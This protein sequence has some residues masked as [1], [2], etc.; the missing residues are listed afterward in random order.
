MDLGKARIGFSWN[1]IQTFVYQRKEKNNEN[2][3]NYSWRNSSSVSALSHLHYLVT[4][5]LLRLFAPTTIQNPTQGINSLQILSLHNKWLLHYLCL[6]L[7]SL[8]FLSPSMATSVLLSGPFHAFSQHSKCKIAT[9]KSTAI[10]LDNVKPIKNP[11]VTL[12]N[13]TSFSRNHLGSYNVLARASIG[14][15]DGKNTVEDE[16]LMGEDSAVFDLEKQKISS[17]LYFGAILGVV[18]FVLDVVWIDNSTGFGKLFIESLSSL[19]DSHEVGFSVCPYGIILDWLDLLHIGSSLSIMLNILVL[20]SAADM[21]DSFS[22][23]CNCFLKLNLNPTKA[24][25]Y[26]SEP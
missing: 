20:C 14:D 15:T 7:F 8:L 12:T 3:I 2:G 16:L 1:W 24:G 4:S 21:Q 19:S 11:T 25:C 17:W 9:L 5:R 6:S 23:R 18:L 22:S 10:F 26:Y 13:T